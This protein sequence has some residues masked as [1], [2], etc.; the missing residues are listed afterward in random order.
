[1]VLTIKGFSQRYRGV[2]EIIYQQSPVCLTAVPSQRAL[3]RFTAVVMFEPL[4]DSRTSISLACCKF[5]LGFISFKIP[6]L[7]LI[8]LDV[9]PHKRVNKQSCIEKKKKAEHSLCIPRPC[10][11]P[12][13]VF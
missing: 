4:P 3:C 7:T 8:M 1:M 5:L 12:H 13:C 2:D 9:R 11:Q 6:D 10:T